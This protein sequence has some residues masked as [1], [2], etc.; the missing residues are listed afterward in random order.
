MPEFYDDAAILKI[1]ACGIC[2]SDINGS[3]RMRPNGGLK[4]LGRETVGTLVPSAGKPRR[5]LAW[6]TATASH[7]ENTFPSA[8]CLQ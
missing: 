7:S 8:W 4:I 3:E 5:S 2:G 1:E 6:R